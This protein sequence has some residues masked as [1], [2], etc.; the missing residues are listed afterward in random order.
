MR[1]DPLVLGHQNVLVE[2]FSTSPL[3]FY[4]AVEAALYRRQIPDIKFTRVTWRESGILSAERIYLR[5][6]RGVLNFDICAAPFGT[7]FFFSWWLTVV[8]ALIE[9]ALVLVLFGFIALFTL[10][11]MVTTFFKTIFVGGSSILG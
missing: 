3:D 7:G 5:V 2:G 1:G 11:S 4:A 10:T 8:P 6:T 9:E